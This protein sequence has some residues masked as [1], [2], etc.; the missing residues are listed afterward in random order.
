MPR[1]QE[2]SQAD[3]NAARQRKNFSSRGH[4]QRSKAAPAKLAAVFEYHE[5]SGLAP[6]APVPPPV[7]K[8]PDGEDAFGFGSGLDASGLSRSARLARSDRQSKKASGKSS[9]T[10]MIADC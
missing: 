9:Q 1:E 6:D 7:R 2:R 10:R 3:R 8:A 5:G 4:E